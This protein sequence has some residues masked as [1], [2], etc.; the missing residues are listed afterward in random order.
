MQ[1]K[2]YRADV[3]IVIST[4]Y[5]GDAW[6]QWIRSLQQQTIVAARYVFMDQQ[7]DE[8]TVAQALQAGFEAYRL[9][10]QHFTPLAFKQC[11]AQQC[12]G[13]RHIVYLDQTAPIGDPCLLEKLLLELQD[14]AIAVAY[15]KQQPEGCSAFRYSALQSLDSFVD[16]DILGQ[17]LNAL[18]WQHKGVNLSLDGMPFEPVRWDEESVLFGLA[19]GVSWVVR[20]LQTYKQKLGTWVSTQWQPVLPIK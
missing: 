7:A 12:A 8:H 17:H 9:N 14:E 16:T 18:G 4:N 6:K 19:Q 2:I 5:A 1:N 10:T 13:A 20:S 3:A 11:A 15:D